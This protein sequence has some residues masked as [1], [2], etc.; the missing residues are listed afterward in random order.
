MDEMRAREVLTA[1]GFPGTAELLA[2][3]ENGVFAAG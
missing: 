2:L 3:G 1:A